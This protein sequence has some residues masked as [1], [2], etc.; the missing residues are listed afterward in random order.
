MNADHMPD[1]STPRIDA[2]E[3]AH[4]HAGME[5]ARAGSG[6]PDWRAWWAIH[7]E[8]ADGSALVLGLKA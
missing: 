1:P 8:H 5:R 4:R 6:V 3:H 2:A 7:G